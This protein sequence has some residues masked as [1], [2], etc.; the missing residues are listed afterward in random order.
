MNSDILAAMHNN[1]GIIMQKKENLEEA[2]QHYFLAIQLK[3]HYVK[4]YL[5]LAWALEEKGQ[6]NQ[7]IQCVYRALTLEPQNHEAIIAEARILEKFGKYEVAFKRILPL[8]SEYPTNIA[9]V[10]TFALLCLRLKQSHLALPLVEKLLQQELSPKYQSN[11]QYLLGH[12][13][14]S[15]QRY[16]EA[17][18]CF[19][20]ANSLLPNSFDP[21]R[22]IHLIEQLKSIF[23]SAF[24]QK[25]TL[26][27]SSR[28]L[29]IVGMP[30]SGTSLVEQILAS[31]SQ[32]GAGGELEDM[33]HF[34]H[35]II[36]QN[37]FVN[38]TSEQLDHY[39]KRY[40]EHLNTLFSQK[41]YVTDKMPTN[42]LYLGF[43]NLV[44][45]QSKVIYCRRNPLDTCLSCYFQNFEGKNPYTQNLKMPIY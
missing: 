36:Q 18:N 43:I 13:Y 20:K 42:F 27:P 28:P 16:D 8:V 24:V 30:R 12:L 10:D 1:M 19:E 26:L 32:V 44:L 9:V 25:S 14:D 17:F 33:S 34:F 15:L 39:A 40:L 38:L 21:V 11:F 29:F 3:P 35:E 6:F 4:P 7:A 2:M 45:P 23:T 41:I 5:N 22:F 37:S 31:H